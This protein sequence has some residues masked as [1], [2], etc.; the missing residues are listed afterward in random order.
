MVHRT[1]SPQPGCVRVTFELPD[2]LWASEVYLTGDFAPGHRH[3]TPMQQERDG[4]WRVTMDLPAG[5]RYQYRYQI[6][7]R[8]YTEWGGQANGGSHDP[9]FSVLDLAGA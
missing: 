5:Q 8:W 4:A 1:R 6:D 3:K 7:T 2:S 9:Q